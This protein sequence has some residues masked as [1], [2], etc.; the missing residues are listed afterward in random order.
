MAGII[1]LPDATPRVSKIR[2]RE[3]ALDILLPK[4]LGVLWR[5]EPSPEG[6]PDQND[7]RLRVGGCM[8]HIGRDFAIGGSAVSYGYAIHAYVRKPGADWMKVFSA[9]LGDRVFYD[10]NF[11][12]W[13]GRCAIL[14]WKRG[15]WEDHLCAER[16]EPRTFAHVQTAGLSCAKEA[17]FR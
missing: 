1:I 8:V 10:K 2:D 12:Y 6:S 3:R 15:S 17:H 16:D 13:G 9:H 7:D 5:G 11:K 14:S 4:F